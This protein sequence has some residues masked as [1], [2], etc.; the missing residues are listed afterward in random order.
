MEFDEQPPLFRLYRIDSR[1]SRRKQPRHGRGRDESGRIAQAPAENRLL[2]GGA[3]READKTN[4]YLEEITMY[5]T[6]YDLTREELE[7]LKMSYYDE[8]QYTDD[9]DY[10]LCYDEIP[11]A[12]IFNHY[13]EI[14]FVDDDFFCNI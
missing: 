7:E 3:P 14:S 2:H 12:V 10:F 4:Y 9:A 13:A 6:V 8:L 1:D 5:K 11:D